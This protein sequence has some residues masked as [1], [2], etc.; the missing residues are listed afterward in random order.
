[1]TQIRSSGLT[2]GH[3]NE[4]AC[5]NQ[6]LNI[7]IVGAGIGGLCAAIAL[8]NSGHTVHVSLKN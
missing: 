4:M 7:V 8:R 1:M 3:T 5:D 6:S 2:N